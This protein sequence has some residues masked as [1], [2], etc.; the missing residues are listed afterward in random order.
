[1][2]RRISLLA[3]G[4]TLTWYKYRSLGI[5]SLHLTC[6]WQIYVELNFVC[7]DVVC[8]SLHTTVTSRCQ[9][10]QCYLN[11]YASVVSFATIYTEHTAP[12]LRSATYKYLLHTCSFPT[13]IFKLVLRLYLLLKPT[14]TLH[15][16]L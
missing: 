7:A 4:C 9:F 1:M 8:G 10:D 2:D 15:C 3:F 13:R 6:F 11:M 5:G 16:R 12:K 14:R